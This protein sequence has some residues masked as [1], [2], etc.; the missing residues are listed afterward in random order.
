MKTKHTKT[1]RLSMLDDIM[2]TAP[3]DWLK[4][5][6]AEIQHLRQA[7]SKA[8]NKDSRVTTGM[9][10]LTPAMEKRR[11]A[12]LLSSLEKLPPEQ[13]AYADDWITLNIF[14]ESY[15]PLQFD[16]H[17]LTAASIW[18]L[19]KLSELDSLH[20]YT[21]SPALSKLYTLLPTDDELLDDLFNVDIWDCRYDEELITSVE[22]VLHYRNQDIAPL[23][24]NGG[25]DDR[26][27]TSNL[28]AEGKDH[29]DVPSRKN[30]EEM[31]S[32][33]P[34][35]MKD[36][37]VKQFEECYQ[38]W[39]DRFFTG[40]AYMQEQYTEKRNALNEIR[41]E[42]NEL[43]DKL[44]KRAAE[45]IDKRKQ[46]KRNAKK[47]MKGSP[48]NILMMKSGLTNEVPPIV[49]SSLSSVVSGFPGM[50]GVS[51]DGFDAEIRSMLARLKELDDLHDKGTEALDNVI[52]KRGKFLYMIVH[53]GYLS[54]ELVSKL[55]PEEM[56]SILMQPIPVSDPYELCFA[57]LYLVET[58]SDI[59]WLYG[60][61]IGMMSEV[62]DYLPWALSDYEE[63][64]DPYWVE[65]P[66]ESRKTPDF[67]NWYS[68]DYVWKGDD[69]YDARSLA[70][71][72]YEATGCLMPRDL[73][74]YD[75][76]LKDLGKYGIKQNKAIAMLY[77]MT[78]LGN[79]RR[80]LRAC[81]LETDEADDTEATLDI[82]KNETTEASTEELLA[83]KSRLEKQIQQLK[84][85]LH[86]AE[87][88]AE[89][90]KRKLEQQQKLSEAEHRELAD[91]REIVFNKD[92]FENDTNET[93]DEPTDSKVY[94]YTVQKS[95]VVFGGHETWVKSLKPLLK[96]DI[97]FIAKEMKIDVSLVRYADAVWI[98]CNA[99]P[100][101]SYYS[102]VNTARKLGKPIRYFTNA[103]AIK[104][105]EQIVE[106]DKRG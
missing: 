34:Q 47:V 40:I 1:E 100:H 92:D 78:M 33:L 96:G 41:K 75:A 18:I 98:Q 16:A 13:Q 62:V 105:A 86:T 101:R 2:Y 25:D 70:Q 35:W 56:H 42:I 95:T 31:L 14:S 52:E 94:P 54:S 90:S 104:C 28:A 7:H 4:R 59:P 69:E 46:T 27:L 23:E 15:A 87:K 6:R 55:F 79:A 37:A 89:D 10:D 67:P 49:S 51:N 91:L 38:A 82:G 66:P 12:A 20:E 97:K 5:I 58:G 17:M 32:L 103:S 73:H 63:L 64:E 81:N 60:S 9:L 93:A 53:H 21:E 71:I 61:C 3:K 24:S 30:F 19:D 102:I 83:E 84:S 88:S 45:Y 39:C 65:L 80:Q 26:V 8:M 44:D 85:A 99:I 72:V 43:R 76:M 36:D 68:R 74:R 22:Y 48:P 50:A 106:N 11:T 29:A 77:C 57:L